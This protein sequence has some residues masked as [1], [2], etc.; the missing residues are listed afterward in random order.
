M[1]TNSNPSTTTGGE[2]DELILSVVMPAFNEAH[3][4]CEAIDAVVGVL[5]AHAIGFEVIVVSDGSTDDTADAARTRASESV[6]VVEYTANRGKGNALTQGSLLARGRWVAWI[7][8]D[9][10]LDA[11]LLPEYLAAAEDGGLDAI[12]GSKRHPGSIVDYPRSRRMGSVAYQALVR[13]LFGLH[14]RDTQVGL[15]LFRREVLAAVLPKVLVKQYAFDLEVLALARHFGF[16]RI[17]EGPVVIR[18]QFSGSGVDVRAI[19]RA[20]WDTAAVFYRMRILR[21]Y[22]R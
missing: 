21:Y 1:T 20:L 22:D 12:I 6:S 7:D 14:V 11:A 9:L 4:V 16:S 15:K 3:V 13:I 5:T 18:Y 10:D 8:A 19:T 2:P 17:E